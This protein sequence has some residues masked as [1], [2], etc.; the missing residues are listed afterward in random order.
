MGEAGY[1]RV[2]ILGD[3]Y[4]VGGDASGAAVAELAAYVEQK[5]KE[6]RRKSS[7]TDP[8]RIA[9]MTSLNL[10]DELFRER[11]LADA[12]LTEMKE[13]AAKMDSVLAITLAEQ[14]EGSVAP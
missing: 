11:A 8:K 2:T 9:V 3:E 6:V 14:A 1:T 5:M 7:M 13:R 4:R 10:A 12:L